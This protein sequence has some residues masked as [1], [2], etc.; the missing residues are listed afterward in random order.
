MYLL[1]SNI[2]IGIINK[3]PNATAHFDNKGHLA[4]VP[5]LVVA[6]LYKGVRCSQRVEKNLTKLEHFL[7]LLPIIPFDREAAEEFGII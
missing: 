5:T 4:Y 3:N 6:E 1:D 2:C 7:L